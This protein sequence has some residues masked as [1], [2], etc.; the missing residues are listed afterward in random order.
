[1]I[2]A[3]AGTFNI[4]HEGH[5]AL[6]DRAFEI[7]DEVFIGIT[8]DRM[9]SSS[10]DK[11]NTYYIREKAVRDYAASKKRPFSIFSIDDMY[12]PDEMMDRVDVLV[13]SEETLGNGEEVVRRASE[14]GRRIELSVVP[15]VRRTDGGKLSSTDV[16][17]GSC[18]RNGETDAIDIAVGSVN[19]VKVEAVRSVMERIFGQV[20]IFPYDVSSDV[21][22]QPFGEQTPEGAKNRAKAAINGHTLSVGIEAGVFEMFGTLYDYQ[23][24]AILDREGRFTIGTGSGFRYPDAVVG[25]VRKGMTVGQAMKEVYGE[26]NVGKTMGAIGVLSKG[27]LDRKSLTE[28]SVLAAMLPRIWDER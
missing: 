4:L 24:C 12:G 26:N 19:P 5:K 21:P 7:G 3:A 14:K 2:S 10:R 9:A 22:E 15:I 13:V 6:L 18:S 23:Y 16:M 11:L 20:R 8:S 25:L 28:Q 17:D 1:M 27:L